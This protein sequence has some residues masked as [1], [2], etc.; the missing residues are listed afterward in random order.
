LSAVSAGAK[1]SYMIPKS[2]L[3]GGGWRGGGG[4]ERKDGVRVGMRAG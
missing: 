3:T 2:Y 4:G 1:T